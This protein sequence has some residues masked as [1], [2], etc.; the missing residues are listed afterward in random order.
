MSASPQRDHKIFS[1]RIRQ[2]HRRIDRARPIFQQYEKGELRVMT[3]EQKRQVGMY[4]IWLED[5]EYLKQGRVPPV[6]KCEFPQDD[7]IEYT[8]A[9]LMEEEEKQEVGTADNEQND[10]HRDEEEKSPT[11]QKN[12]TQKETNTTMDDE[13]IGDPETDKE[14]ILQHLRTLPSG[15][16]ESFLR[17]Y[18]ERVTDTEELRSVI[19]RYEAANTVR[20][21]ILSGAV[22]RVSKAQLE[23]VAE[24]SELRRTMNFLKQQKKKEQRRLESFI[25][26]CLQEAD[27]EEE[28][29]EEEKE[30]YLSTPDKEET[31]ERVKESMSAVNTS[32]SR[33]PHSMPSVDLELLEENEGL[34]GEAHILSLQASSP[35]SDLLE[36]LAIEE[37][38]N[39]KLKTDE[40]RGTINGDQG[41][42]VENV[43]EKE[44]NFIENL[45][46]SGKSSICGSNSVTPALTSPGFSHGVGISSSSN[47]SEREHI[48]RSVFDW[49][50][51]KYNKNGIRL[52]TKTVVPQES[53]SSPDPEKPKQKQ[54]EEEH[55][56]QR[57]RP[58]DSRDVSTSLNGEETTLKLFSK[59][60]LGGRGGRSEG[61]TGNAMKD[62]L[63]YIR[64]HIPFRDKCEDHKMDSQNTTTRGLE[65][66][67]SSTAMLRR[68]ERELQ[69]IQRF[70]VP[71]VSVAVSHFLNSDVNE[72][73][74]TGRSHSR[75]GSGTGTPTSLG[76]VHGGG[77]D[78]IA[79]KWILHVSPSDGP[80]S[81]Q[82]I[83]VVVAFST[84]YPFVPPLVYSTVF[85][86]LASVMISESGQSNTLR[87][88]WT[89]SA[90]TPSCGKKNINETRAE[91]WKPNYNIRN[92]LFQVKNFFG[93]SAFAA[94]S[95]A[96]G[97]DLYRQSIAEA[98]LACGKLIAGLVYGTT[99]KETY[100][101]YNNKVLELVNGPFLIS[102]PI[103]ENT[104]KNKTEKRVETDK[105]FNNEKSESKHPPTIHY[106]EEGTEGVIHGPFLGCWGHLLMMNTS[107]VSEGKEKVETHIAQD[108]MNMESVLQLR[109][110]TSIGDSMPKLEL[111]CFSQRLLSNKDTHW[112]KLALE[113]T[114][115]E[116][117]DDK[118]ISEEGEQEQEQEQKR[119]KQRKSASSGILSRFNVELATGNDEK[120]V[121][122]KFF[123][124]DAAQISPLPCVKDKTMGESHVYLPSNSSFLHKKGELIP[125]AWAIL[126]HVEDGTSATAIFSLFSGKSD[127]ESEKV[128]VNTDSNP[129]ISVAAI[130]NDVNPTHNECTNGN[131]T[132]ESQS[133]PLFCVASLDNEATTEL[134]GVLC[135]VS[136]PKMVSENYAPDNINVYSSMV[137]SEGVLNAHF[138][139]SV[140]GNKFFILSTPF[141]ACN[142]YLP[143]VNLSSPLLSEKLNC[144][145]LSITQLYRNP[146][147][148]TAYIPPFKVAEALH[149]F[150]LV[151]KSLGNEWNRFEGSTKGVITTEMCFLKTVYT[152]ALYTFHQLVKDETKLLELCNS[153]ATGKDF[154]KRKSTIHNSPTVVESLDEVSILECLLASW[155]TQYILCRDATNLVG[156]VDPISKCITNAS[157]VVEKCWDDTTTEL[158][159][160]LKEE[161]K[162]E[163]LFKAQFQIGLIAAVTIT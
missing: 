40:L 54:Q 59:K 154:L 56:Q 89:C 162:E 29:E 14:R 22:T 16:R 11:N 5:L 144:L 91:E 136:Y 6:R 32:L 24:L 139:A 116:G 124:T 102:K 33:D 141:V 7:G 161:G 58:Q 52:K 138:T 127:S 13:F 80:L 112:A 34:H 48:Q 150:A 120:S 4:S 87:L 143:L 160:Y 149:F 137:V 55:Q 64:L 65:S 152:R 92:L 113:E 134:L 84:L 100:L 99:S 140:R 133:M 155:A 17:G 69:Y 45:S 117:N 20:Q 77:D 42:P 37:S 94:S 9:I 101:E 107:P 157:R 27:L 28:E 86:P 132:S 96:L 125:L 156:V 73:N 12:S 67:T 1:E 41:S 18:V 93:A 71:C 142:F 104:K 151:F 114:E 60:G 49:S 23:M 38:E 68:L 83:Q 30:N 95:N 121:L 128:L 126:L 8:D 76:S 122:V 81:G 153:I 135:E 108:K 2:L 53:L 79:A 148:S 62:P 85:L 61:K 105:L 21:K 43:I 111:V 3:R 47:Y 51:L 118:K 146:E 66:Q 10:D 46:I 115:E 88:P 75:S 123:F 50:K 25:V 31:S 44:N 119:K 106:Y 36:S 57:R 129:S 82:V 78:T 98:R 26:Q 90:P 63:D 110:M 19:K 109:L 103:E 145:K 158:L 35:A 15:T 97:Q 147:A 74:N 163:L 70:P 72:I 130:A 159:A 39:N 131:C